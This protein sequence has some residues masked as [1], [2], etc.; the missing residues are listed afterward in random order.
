V[1]VTVAA[2]AVAAEAELLNPLLLLLLHPVL[3]LMTLPQA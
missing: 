2:V 1:V 3:L